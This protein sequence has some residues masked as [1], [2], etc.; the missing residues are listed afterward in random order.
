MNDYSKT[1]LEEMNISPNFAQW[2]VDLVQDGL[3]NHVVEIGCG[4]GRNLDALQK[5]SKEIFSIMFI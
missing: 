5:I 1:I 2:S 4:I 3:T